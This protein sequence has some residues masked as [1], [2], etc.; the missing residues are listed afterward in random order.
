MGAGPPGALMAQSAAPGKAVG[1][2]FAALSP[3][4]AAPRA[5]GPAVLS[6]GG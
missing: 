3:S 6:G 5:P 2:A 4:G 1:G